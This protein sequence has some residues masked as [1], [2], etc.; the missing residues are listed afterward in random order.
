MT[1]KICQE[2]NQRNTKIYKKGKNMSNK[3]KRNINK[4][5]RKKGNKF[6][7]FIHAYMFY[8][9]QYL[10]S[11]KETLS[12]ITFQSDEANTDRPLKEYL[13]FLIE[14]DF[15]QLP[16]K[17]EGGKLNFENGHIS[18]LS[19]LRDVR[20]LKVLLPEDI[21]EEIKE[22]IKD[23]KSAV[24]TNPDMCFVLTDGVSTYYE[25][26]ELKS[27]KHDV[28][29]GSSVQQIMPD[30]WVIFIK[31]TSKGIDVATGKYVHSIN[32]K[33]PFPDRSP[34]PQVSFKQLKTWNL[35]YRNCEND[36][37]V[38]VYDKNTPEKVKQ[39]LNWQAVLLDRWLNIIQASSR[40]P[41]ESWFNDS[42][43]KFTLEVLHR[44]DALSKDKQEDFKAQLQNGSGA[45]ISP[46]TQ[47]ISSPEKKC[48]M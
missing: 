2:N 32:S 41:S 34:R 25:T 26:V 6:N 11:K 28:I 46:T 16:Q 20:I 35:H 48:E 37:I 45:S 5:S 21:T 30:E 9:E 39:I 44:Y 29:P 23:T 38:Y 15:N 7:N 12:E 47:E 40:A 24:Y 3:Y 19:E 22:K 31:H 18:P 14:T 17:A 42:I 33:M 1:F 27:T 8:L 36:M 10:L 4:K 43:R 13:R